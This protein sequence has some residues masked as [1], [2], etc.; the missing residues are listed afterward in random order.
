M[1]K[2]SI[3]YKEA[4]KFEDTRFEKIHNVIFDSSLEA[5]ILVAQEIANLIQRKQELNETCVLGL[6]TGSSPIKVYEELVRMH[7]EDGLSFK[8]VVTFNLDEYY[9]MDKD[10]IQSYFYFMHDHLFNHVDILPENVN[11]PDGKVS[12]EELQQYC[13]DYEMKIKSYGGL[14]F[15]LLGIGRTG[16]IGFN[17]PGSHINSGTR[18]I[19]LDH[20][21]RIDAAPSFLGIDN[22][23]RKAITMGIGTVRHAKRIVLLGW[24]I[25]KAE[26]LK[27]T[28]EGT[29][30]SQ[31]PATYLQ[32]H[33]NTTFVLDSDASSELTRVKTPWLV[34][35]CVWSDALKLKAVVW[36]SEL[37][38]KPFL[39]LTDKD[40]N[41]NGMASLLTEE[42]T[43][44]DLNIKMFNKLQHTITGWPGGKPNADDTYRPERSTPL[45]KRVIIFSPHPDDDVISM[46]GTF[47]RLVEQGHD[48]HVAYQTS[49]NIAVSNEEAL[50]FA[51]ISMT[52]NPESIESKKIIDFLRNKAKND[53][54]SIEVRKLKGLIRRSES[55]AATR[56]IGL[57]DKNVHFLDLP[58]YET[59]TVKK[60]NLSE[61]DIAIMCQF[62]EEIKPHQI[63][64]AGDLADPHG[65]HKVCLDSLFETLKILKPKPYMDDCW[66]WLYRGAWHEWDSYQIE[67][68]VPM[69][70]DQV[71]KKRHAIF[72]HQSQKDGVMFQ[73]DD[74]REFWVRVEDRNRL[75]AKKY[76]DLGLAEYAAIEAFKRYHF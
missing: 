13:I 50:K 68:A 12:A 76:N 28:I 38:N 31:V 24:G 5:S 16:H 69:S 53:I 67:M 55:L 35:S 39:K 46:G 73:G 25:S 37:T 40:Y 2:E 63:Y 33:N 54:D 14:D 22:V 65:T 51:E 41:D 11:V 44:Y 58:F 3:S 1:I 32:E 48:V 52:L 70:P 7:K 49:G 9:P 60:S 19:T 36:L 75:T 10:N 34:K 42:G 62:I 17:E 61:A 27:K 66:V 59:G 30:S 29:I 57:P 64:A 21:T 20:I 47:N 43:A 56:Y 6:A 45:K 72:Y 23:P 26:I 18:S 15:Q 8:N 71:L 4:G 74:S